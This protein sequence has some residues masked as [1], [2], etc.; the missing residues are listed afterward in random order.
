MTRI[1]AIQS[2]RLTKDSKRPVDVLQGDGV[3]G[4]DAPNLVMPQASP[5]VRQKE[6]PE[7]SDANIPS[8][9]SLQYEDETSTAMV[10]QSRKRS[11]S[12]GSDSPRDAKRLKKRE[13]QLLHREGELEKR[14]MLKSEARKRSRAILLKG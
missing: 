14:K 8:P 11:Q 9:S 6:D 13:A 4:S 1:H 2:S 7:D 12:N 5:I 3:V 10:F